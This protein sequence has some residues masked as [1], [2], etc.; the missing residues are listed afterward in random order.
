MVTKPY[1]NEEKQADD[2]TNNLSN[3][4]K[5]LKNDLLN[6]LITK[7]E[8]EHRAVP[9]KLYDYLSKPVPIELYEDYLNTLYLMPVIGVTDNS[10]D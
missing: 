8:E 4:R 2:S 10:S 9:K 5:V 3:I 1:E 6:Q 7:L